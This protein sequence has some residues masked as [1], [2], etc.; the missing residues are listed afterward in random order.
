MSLDE[1]DPPHERERSIG[2]NAM[3]RMNSQCSSRGGE[4]PNKPLQRTIPPQGNRGNINEP[5]VR[6][7]R[8]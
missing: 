4:L 6:R 2:T 5:F 7:A 3:F 8:R 1:A